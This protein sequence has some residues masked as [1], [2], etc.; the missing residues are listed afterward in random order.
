MCVI[1]VVG[2]S[3]IVDGGVDV[4]EV[5]AVVVGVKVSGCGTAVVWYGCRCVVYA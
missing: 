1:V 4:C 2:V 3:L 5:V